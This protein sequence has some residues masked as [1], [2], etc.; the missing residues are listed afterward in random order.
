M[1]GIIGQ[2]SFDNDPKQNLSQVTN[3]LSLMFRRGPDDEGFWSDG[4]RM[5]LGFRR[6]AILDLSPAGHQP[7]LSADGRFAL[8]FN[9]EVYNFKELR[10]QLEQKGVRF[11][12][13]SDAEV[14]LY[15]LA[16]W[17]TAAL[18]RFNGIFALGFY[19]TLQNRLL[20][21]R[22]HA[23][24]KP[25]YLL[26]SQR[27]LVF[28]S[29]Y[30]QI[31]AHPWARDL[32]VDQDALA[33]YLRFGYIPAPYALLQ[34]TSLLKAGTWLQVDGRGQI[35]QDRFFTF[36]C[37]Q[38]PQ[39][40]GQ[41]ALEAVEAAVVNA[42]RRQMISD[43]PLGAFLSGGIDS[44]LV[45]AVAQSFSADPLKAFTLGVEDDRMDETDDALQYGVEIGVEHS[46]LRI[47]MA[48]VEKLVGQVV[49][50]CSEPFGD[51]SIFPT[52]L[53]AQFASQQVKVML[54]GDGGDE[55]FW[56]YTGRMGAAI[57]NAPAF[58]RPFWQRKLR[59]HALRRSGEWNLSYF[60]TPGEWY[61]SN[62]EHNFEAWLKGYFP[63]LAPLP[64]SYQQYDY[65]GSN[66]DETAQW[67]RWN[68]FTGHMANGLLKVDRG[69][70]YHSLEV[71]VPL[72]DREV[73]ETALNVD[74]RTC[75]DL[76]EGLGK[77]PLRRALQKRVQHQ[78][79]SKRGFTVPMEDWLRGPLKP[80]FEDLVLGRKEL[81][82]LQLHAPALQNAFKRHLK[83]EN[84]GWG[85]WIILS[86][87]LWQQKYGKTIEAL[88]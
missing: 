37:Y 73:I 8:V 38:Q 36:P 42:V 27:G 26:R 22:D 21:A 43:V 75:L 53:L 49:E 76:Q 24:V 87:A 46:I 17:G 14:V 2:I 5:A 40:S 33:L 9:G 18:E 58:R 35:T 72:L 32:P 16:E 29:Q 10:L 59:W 23:G 57:R 78:S 62:H 70:M 82:G 3:L 47:H 6:L 85:L 74:W 64:E 61:R 55:L 86:L 79:G 41:E 51:Y 4:A 80:F 34:N 66:P 60:K 65:A 13:T 67:V 19:D 77:L 88:R 44:P 1:C 45:A 20:L 84:L 63:T 68:E 48:D 71:R 39:L 11:R 28:A 54:S 25:L 12:S 56:G 69:S 30:D 83:G 15:A 52:M 50:A 81:L 7:M 31:L